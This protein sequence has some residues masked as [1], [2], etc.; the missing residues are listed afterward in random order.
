MKKNVLFV[1]A[2]LLL[3]ASCSHD[4]DFQQPEPQPQ[5]QPNQEDAIKSNVEKIFGI[6]IDPNQDWCTTQNGKVTITINNPELKDVEKVQILTVSPFGNSDAN[7]AL[8]LNEKKVSFG[9]SVTLNYDAPKMYNRLYAAC[10]KKNGEY[11][12]KGF[13]VGEQNVVFTSNTVSSARTRSGAGDFDLDALVNSLPKDPVLEEPEISFNRQR[14]WNGW[15]N[16]LLYHLS[17]TAE[18]AQCLLVSDYTTDY[19]TDL[20][21][22][23]FNGYLQNKVDNIGKIKKSEYYMSNNNYPFTTGED[24]IILAPIYKND[25]IYHE[26]ENCDIY[27]YYFK[28]EAIMGMTEAEQ[29]QYL[30]NLPKYKVVELYTSIVD[31]HEMINNQ[32]KRETAYALIYWGD[33]TPVPGQTKGKYSFPEGYK[34]GFMLRSI[35]TEENHNNPSVGD[36][37]DGELYCDGRLNTDINKF[38]HFKS[39]KLDPN[40]PRMAWFWANNR[41]YL[42]CESG[43]DKDFNDIVFEVLGGIMVPPPPT[44]DKNKYTFCFEDTPVGDYDLNDVVIRAY[45]Y[46]ATHVVW[47]VVACGAHDEVYIKNISGDVI[48]EETEVHQMFG[49]S[50]KVFINTEKKKPETPI[51]EEMVEVDENFSFLKNDYQPY[52]YDKTNKVETRLSIAGE[53]PHAIMVPYE[54]RYPL[55]KIC[56]KDAYR[57]F[58]DWAQGYGITDDEGGFKWY[59][60]FDENKVTEAIP[61]LELE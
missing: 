28:P 40:D 4:M 36:K 50:G 29:V 18:A 59:L 39:S 22:M 61:T 51:V 8:S 52:I 43:S 3:M 19:K 54:F 46:D 7:G 24:P 26:I 33:G 30:K 34:I 27:Y 6:T 49:K 37:R 2:G 1:V 35:D 5:P 14:N 58:K 45:R 11:F 32:I 13:N 53:D 20:Y 12:I 47:Q 17:T 42:C 48:N 56:I 21:D 10:V 38:G 44:I 16:D 9:Q 25:G 31:P 55:E 57:Y 23:I 60:Y 41:K 15:E